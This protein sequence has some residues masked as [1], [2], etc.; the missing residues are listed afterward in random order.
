LYVHESLGSFFGE[1][2]AKKYFCLE[3]GL[4]LKEGDTIDDYC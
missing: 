2:G 4:E 1:D 3:Q